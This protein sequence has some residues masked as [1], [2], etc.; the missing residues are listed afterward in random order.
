MSNS[1]ARVTSF[2]QYILKD[3]IYKGDIVVDATMG[4]GNDTLFLAN[5][6]GKEGTVFAFDIQQVALDRTLKKIHDNNLHKYNIHLIKDSHEFIANYIHNPID[7]AM[8]NL[9]YLPKGDHLIITKPDSTIKGIKTILELLKPRGIM[10][11]VI[12]Y[13]HEGGIEEK[14]QVLNFLEGLSNEDFIVMKSN[15]INQKNSPPIIVFVEK[16]RES[17]F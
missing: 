11:I 9:G 3:K 12:Y 17:C 15:Y 13:G 1:I 16:T 10:S 5:L 14:K 2:V 6:V 4:N 7:I 8:F